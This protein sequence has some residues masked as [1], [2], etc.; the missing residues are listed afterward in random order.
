[1]PEVEMMETLSASFVGAARKPEVGILGARPSMAELLTPTPAVA[2][3]AAAVVSAPDA[4]LA[5]A[6]Q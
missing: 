1:M 4:A 6:C 5:I 2:A 3:V